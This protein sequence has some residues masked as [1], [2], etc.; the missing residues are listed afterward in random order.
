MQRIGYFLIGFYLVSSVSFADPII[1]DHACT[2]LTAIPQSELEAAK[3][4]LVI[5]YGHTSHG[6]QI[7]TG[8]SG[9]VGFANGGGLGMSLPTDFFAW[10]NGGIDGALDLEE[11]DGYGDGW[12]DHDCGYYPNWVDETREY[13]DDPSHSDVNVIIWSWCGQAAGRTEAT[14][15]STYLAPMTQL[16]LDYP[17]VTFVYMTGHA[18]GSGETGNLHLRNQQIRQYCIDNDKVLFDF[19]DIECYDP[20]DN[21]YGD[22]DVND[23]CDYDSDGN[24]SLDSNWAIDWQNAHTENVDW[25]TCSSAHSQPLNA[26]RKAYAAWWLWARLAGWMQCLEAPSDLTADYND[27]TGLVTL[28]WND[29]SS[30]PNED[31]FIIQRQ[32]DSNPWNNEYATVNSDV[33]TFGEILTVDGSYRYRVVARLNDDGSGSPCDSASSNTATVVLSHTPPEA[34]SNLQC[35]LL[36]TDIRLTWVD[37][38]DNE[39]NFVLERRIDDG[40]FVILDDAIASDAQ[41]YIDENLPSQHTY[42]Y[43]LKACNA[44]GDSDWSNTASQYV[45]YATYTI[46]LENTSVV[47]DSFIYQD[48]P[49]SNYGS[50]T[51][52]PARIDNYIVKFNFP[53]ELI[54]MR[55]LDARIAFYGWSV[56]Y[57]QDNQFMQLY[58]VT[59]DWDESSVTWNQASTGQP[60]STPGGDYDLLLGEIPFVPDLN[61]EFY[62]PVDI[63]DIVQKWLR[64]KGNHLY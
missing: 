44:N 61:H 46:R 27:L 4:N 49:N 38:S 50:N 15:I 20:D 53:P 7:T 30:D 11:G 43:R 33:T 48:D 45:P 55:I 16:E 32:V 9:L 29:N 2:D 54:G 58:R 21:Y 13:L 42:Y 8:M 28:N 6:S 62:P 23:N 24:G 37:N 12:M 36:G 1:V 22:K 59:S 19:Y 34:P 31:S 60:W 25:Y 63:T 64:G 56:I 26:N 5:A 40:E 52:G 57:N 35:E 47:E 39:E 14:M 10:N 17:D 18:D 41:S 51:W 3:A